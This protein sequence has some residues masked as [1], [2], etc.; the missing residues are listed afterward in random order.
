MN[1]VNNNSIIIEIENEYKKID[2]RW[3]KLHYHTFIA[4]FLFGFLIECILGIKLYIGGYIE[5]PLI[6]YV[7][8]YILSPLILNS[9]LVLTGIFAMNSSR[10]QQKMKCYLISL[11]FVGVCFVLYSVHIIFG[12]IYLIFTLPVLLTLIYSDYVL[13]TVIAFVSFA[14]KIVS[15]LSITWDPD[16]INFFNSTYGLTDCVISICIFFTFYVVCIVVIHFEKEKI[17]VSMQKEIER[18]QMQQNL[19]TDEL[20]KVFNRTALRNALK[21][22]EE[23]SSGN[24]YAF[25]MIDLDNFKTLNDKLGHE[26][27]DQ[28]LKEFGSIL[29]LNCT[30]SEPFRYGGDEFCIIFKNKTSTEIMQTCKNIQ[31][32]LKKSTAN[33]SGILL[34]VSIGI[35]QYTKQISVKQLLKNSDLAMYHSKKFKNRICD[36]ESLAQ[37]D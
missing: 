2:N 36:H 1:E 33:E 26:K 8:K 29:T 11:L 12:S 37:T 13:T 23:D 5:I 30:D 28:C 15:E 18:Y 4:L 16:K 34:T 22:M 21:N 35:A 9:C 20:T 3:L 24:T 17:S 7:L 6:D 14:S 10:L 19:I 31:N 32:D 27:G 25:A